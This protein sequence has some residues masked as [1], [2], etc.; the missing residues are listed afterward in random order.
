[1]GKWTY[2]VPLV[3]E[4]RILRDDVRLR[5]SFFIVLLFSKLNLMLLLQIHIKDTIIGILSFL[6][7]GWK[8]RVCQM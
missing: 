7:R 4:D 8:H 3:C 6:L 1:M 2:Q 5:N